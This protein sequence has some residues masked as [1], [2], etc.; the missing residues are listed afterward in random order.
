MIAHTSE[1][2]LMLILQHANNLQSKSLVHKS[3]RNLIDIMMDPRIYPK[4]PRE[5]DSI[6]FVSSCLK[7]ALIFEGRV[8]HQVI[9]LSSFILANPEAFYRSHQMFIHRITRIISRFGAQL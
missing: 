7:R 3:F 6:D 9:Y 8:N 1:Q 5:N 2:V 4:L